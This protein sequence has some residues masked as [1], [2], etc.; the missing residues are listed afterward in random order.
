LKQK[1]EFYISLVG[2]A[3][4]GYTE[5]EWQG[6]TVYIKHVNIRDQR[7]LH[8]YYEKY[9]K[10]ALDRGLDTEEDRIK[11]VLSEGIW[12][13]NDDA[14]IHGLEFEISNLKKTLRNIFLPSQEKKVKNS[15][16][17][18]S[19]ELSELKN[20]RSDVIGKTAEDYASHRSADEILRFLLF[21][22]KELTEHL[23]TEEEFGRLEVWEV[24]RLTAL[25]AN[26]SERLTDA[27]IQ[28]A[29]LRPFFSLYLSLCEDI[30]GFYRKPITE[31]TIYQLR[32]GL[33]GRMFS[34]IFQFTDN[35]PDDIRQDPERLLAYHESQHNKDEK[36]KRSGIREDADASIVFGATKEDVEYLGGDKDSSSLS[37]EAK[38]HGGKL[39]MKQMMRLAGHDV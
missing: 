26:I 24:S 21:K 29:V 2:E 9:K 5:V 37:K 4:D 32:V 14:R 38:K 22:N 10:I 31:L 28:E 20:K 30:A 27:R 35:I 18:K 39:D 36:M 34:N 33:F 15:I 11:Y 23:Y 12:D 25:H 16:S 7:Y 6:E 8:K 17:E 3:F 19:K 13:E 1:E